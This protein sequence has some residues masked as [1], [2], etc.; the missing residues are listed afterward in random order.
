MKIIFIIIAA[1]LYIG[2]ILA[3]SNY[4]SAKYYLINYSFQNGEGSFTIKQPKGGEMNMKYAIDHL[5]EKNLLGNKIIRTFQEISK[6]QFI[7]WNEPSK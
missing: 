3:I 1:I 5:N 2:T 4:N 7:A 6:D